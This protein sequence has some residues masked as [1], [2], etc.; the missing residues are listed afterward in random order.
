MAGRV[1]LLPGP[2]FRHF[3]FSSSFLTW[4]LSV[5]LSVCNRTCLISSNP[6]LR[7]GHGFW[8]LYTVYRGFLNR[9][10]GILQL[11]YGYSEYHF[12]W[13]SGIKYTYL[14]WG[15]IFGYF[16]EFFSG[17]LVYHYPPW[18]TLITWYG[19]YPFSVTTSQCTKKK[20]FEG[21]LNW[22]LFYYLLLLMVWITYVYKYTKATTG[23]IYYIR[24]YIYIFLV[25]MYIF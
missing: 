19:R 15:G 22:I 4:V 8:P 7:V 21:Y 9:V 25:Y 18:P 11:K 24:S 10:Y 5:C 2:T 13:I 17:I 16:G 6:L 20:S 1:T 12:L 23:S 3:S 14:F